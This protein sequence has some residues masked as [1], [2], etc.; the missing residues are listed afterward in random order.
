MLV[1]LCFSRGSHNTA[2]F[3]WNY[4]LKHDRHSVL[5]YGEN[6]LLIALM[7]FD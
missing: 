3:L 1:S 4:Y 7:G 5:Y 6:T 2:P